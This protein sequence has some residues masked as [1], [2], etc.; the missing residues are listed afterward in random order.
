MNRLLTDSAIRSTCRELLAANRQIS[1]RELRRTLQARYQAVGQTARVFRIWR[2]EQAARAEKGRAPAVSPN[3]SALLER[4]DI[5]EAA[6][7]ENLQRAE[8]AELRE[9]SHQDRWAMEIDTLRQQVRNQ[10]KYAAEI[11]TLQERVLRL[12]VELHATRQLL[13]EKS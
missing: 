8:R 13:A 1:G 10:P 11:R 6:A 5:A 2:E 3:T 4:L 9:Q 7:R 12:T